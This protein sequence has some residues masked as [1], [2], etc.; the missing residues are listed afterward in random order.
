MRVAAAVLLVA[1]FVSGC[2]D[3]AKVYARSDV[4]RSFRSQGLDLV[5]P[6]L[7][8]AAGAHAT[9]LVPNSGQFVV[10]VYENEKRANDAERAFQAT[11]RP[12]DLHDGN[13]IVTSNKNI[14]P[15]VRQQIRDA[16]A[17]LSSG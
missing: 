7:Q 9:A 12:L 16:L 17:A 11:T 3:R 4:E 1:A 2:A 10:L 8:P 6:P 15:P 5:S 14:A 13:V